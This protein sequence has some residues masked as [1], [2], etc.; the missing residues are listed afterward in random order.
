MYTALKKDQCFSF[1]FKRY[2]FY[3]YN[4]RYICM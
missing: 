3:I 2:L 1:G 4:P